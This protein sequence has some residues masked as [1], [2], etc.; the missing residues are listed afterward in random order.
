MWCSEQL[1]QADKMTT[2]GILVSG[3]A[4]E[5]NN[6]NNFIILNLSILQK[7]W[8]DALPV[9]N[10][11]VKNKKNF[12]MANLK[13]SVIKKNVPTL[14]EGMV[15]ASNRIGDIVKNLK[16]F[17]RMET[18]DLNEMVNINTAVD[19][20]INFLSILIKKSTRFFSLQKG[21]NI[22]L[23]KGNRHRLE[24]VF[25][26]F[27]ENSC[28]ALRNKNQKIL[29]KTFF[30]ADDK[31]VTIKIIDEGVGIDTENMEKVFDPFFTTKRS[32]GGTGL[33][34]SVSLKIMKAHGGKIG[35]ISNKREGTTGIIKLPVTVYDLIT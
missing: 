5:I 8:K 6:P 2:L 13:Y 11:H 29:I 18:S 31:M 15:D 22:P 1:F 9:L 35:F 34:L 20:A 7:I 12:S 24:Q 23:I 25:I 4:H 16:N 17:A 21:K 26:N 33:G 28:Q 30:D 32:N 19:N 27:I 10:N 3:V 14:F